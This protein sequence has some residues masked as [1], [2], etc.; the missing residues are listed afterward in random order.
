M[1]GRGGVDLFHVQNIA[2]NYFTLILFESSC[3]LA[4]R[5]LAVFHGESLMEESEKYGQPTLYAFLYF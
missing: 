2:P 1:R 5:A 3:S 4:S